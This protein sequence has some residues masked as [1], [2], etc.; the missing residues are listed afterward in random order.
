MDFRNVDGAQE[1][2]ESRDTQFASRILVVNNGGG[3]MRIEL[4]IC[5]LAIYRRLLAR[6]SN[7]SALFVAF[8]IIS[9]AILSVI[10]GVFGAY[11]AICGV[12]AAV[13]PSRP[14]LVLRA[15]VQSQANGD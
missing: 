14:S 13:N 9:T 3:Q 5:S 4:N 6:A 12:L 10:L 15:L 11:W 8:L 1:M 2:L 7:V